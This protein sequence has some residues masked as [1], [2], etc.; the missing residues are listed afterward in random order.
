[1]HVEDAVRECAGEVR[2]ENA[3]EA[4]KHDELRLVLREHLDQR[5]VER[6]TIGELARFQN[7]RRDVHRGCG[8]QSLCRGFVADD[9][10]HLDRQAAR[11]GALRDDAHVRAAAEDQN[12]DRQR[13]HPR[14]MTP[15]S[16]RRTSPMTA[17]CSPWSRST[18]SARSQCSAATQTVMPIPQLKVRYISSCGILPARCSHS[19]TGG[20]LHVCALSRTSRPCGTTRGM[21]S[22]RPPPV[23]CA[24]LCTATD[25]ASASSGL[26]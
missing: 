12:C 13:T 26:T 19:N 5:S 16:P 15:P 6:C 22:V 3:H 10:T 14:M 9:D 20:W 23:M 7:A 24:K 17:G 8:L 4:G 11:G 25:L 1:M 18:L 21:F 2:R